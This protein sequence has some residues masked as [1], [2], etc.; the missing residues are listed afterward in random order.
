MP[1]KDTIIQEESEDEVEIIDDDE[2][3]DE[4]DDEEEITLPD[5]MQTF[6][7]GENGKNLVDTVYDLK[8]SIDVQN[9]ILSK[10]VSALENSVLKNE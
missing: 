10:L 2:E 3:E 4:E 1:K 7:A 9:K 8:K 6:F 5:L